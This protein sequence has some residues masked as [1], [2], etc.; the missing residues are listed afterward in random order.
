VEA[1]YIGLL[2]AVCVAIAWFAGRVVYML[3]RGQS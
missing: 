3:L 2:V 1:F